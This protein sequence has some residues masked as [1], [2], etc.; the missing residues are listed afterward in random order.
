VCIVEKTKCPVSD[1]DNAAST[2]SLSLISQITTISGSSLI[3]DLIAFI[4]ES[5]SLH[6]SL[7]EKKHPLFSNKNSIGSSIVIIC[8]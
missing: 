5:V 7:C 2:V 8:S 4:K 6:I 3:E 1:S